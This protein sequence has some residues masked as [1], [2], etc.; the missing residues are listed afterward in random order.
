MQSILAS[1]LAQRPTQPIAA[2]VISASAAPSGSSTTEKRPM[3]GIHDFSF[4]AVGG[5]VVV[6]LARSRTR[7]WAR[8]RWGAAAS[9]AMP[10][11]I[12]ST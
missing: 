3:F 4:Y 12:R 11:G 10:S 7:A 9:K 5:W 1:G 2:G 8:I 6:K